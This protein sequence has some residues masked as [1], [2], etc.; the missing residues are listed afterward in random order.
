MGCKDVRMVGGGAVGFEGTSLFGL[1]GALVLPLP[2][3]SPAIPLTPLGIGHWCCF[4][5]LHDV[6]LCLHALHCWCG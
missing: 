5:A 3:S 2:F 6:N 1:E 4:S